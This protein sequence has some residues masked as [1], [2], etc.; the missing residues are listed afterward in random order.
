MISIITASYNYAEFI[1]EAIESVLAQTFSDWEMI[2]VDDGS[3]D[4][5]IEIIKG[6]CKKDDRIKLFC[7]EKNQNLGLRSTIKLGLSK[8]SGEY[9]AFLESDDLWTKDYLAEKMEKFNNFPQVSIIFNDIEPF[10][11]EKL[12]K[13]KKEYFTKREKLLKGKNFPRKIFDEMSFLNLITTFSSA[14][15]KREELEKVKYNSTIPAYLDYWIWVQIVAKTEVFYINKKMTR[16]R[17]HKKSYANK[18]FGKK[19]KNFMSDML[20]MLEKEKKVSKINIFWKRHKNKILAKILKP[21][22]FMKIAKN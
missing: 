14:M 15:V 2:I 10:G 17:L 19:K 18:D 7:H 11:E 4:N 1:S 22:L 8:S 9:I 20:L 13:K 6:Y 12:I 5:S 16:W 3:S 21:I